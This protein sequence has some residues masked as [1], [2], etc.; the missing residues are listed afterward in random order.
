MKISN[1]LMRFFILSL[2][3]ITLFIF[4]NCANMI[5]YGVKS[6]SDAQNILIEQNG[7]ISVSRKQQKVLDKINEKRTVNGLEPLEFRSDLI[8][9][10]RLKAEDFVNNNYL[11]HTSENY[12]TIFDMLKE[13]NI[14][15]QIAG[16]NLAGT[17]TIN[18][19]VNGWMNSESHRDNIL[20]ER[21]KY[22][23]IYIINS[24]VY[25]QIYVQVFLG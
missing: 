20:E 24:K 22:T 13:N 2:I 8:E 17:Q 6:Y 25:G 18:L 9:L 12:G 1:Y 10:A 7:T 15:Y 3:M 5:V 19:A 23:G 16:E 4:Y 21:Y 11:S 14:K